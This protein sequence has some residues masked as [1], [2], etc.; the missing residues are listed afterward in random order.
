MLKIIE[1]AGRTYRYYL[2][3][4]E[5]KIIAASLQL[6]ERVLLPAMAAA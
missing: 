3:K 5:K 4:L 6:K 1:R 2:T